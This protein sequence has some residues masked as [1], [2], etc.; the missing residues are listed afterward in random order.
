[1]NNHFAEQLER[2]ASRDI[3]GRAQQVTIGGKEA[4]KLLQQKVGNKVAMSGEQIAKRGQRVG[5][6]VKVC[7][8]DITEQLPHV[9]AVQHGGSKRLVAQ[10][11]AQH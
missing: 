1:M 2:L 4:V 9:L 11:F 8:F 6:D 7:T 10:T 3:V 5:G